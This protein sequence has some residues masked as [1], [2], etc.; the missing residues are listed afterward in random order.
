MHFD[1]VPTVAQLKQRA[2]AEIKTLAPTCDPGDID[3]PTSPSGGLYHALLHS[4]KGLGF[5][6]NT[7]SDSS[8]RP[9]FPCALAKSFTSGQTASN[10]TAS[11]SPAGSSSTTAS[12]SVEYIRPVG[13]RVAA[14]VD[15]AS[16]IVPP[17]ASSPASSAALD[18][19]SFVSPPEKAVVIESPARCV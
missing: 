17:V 13:E 5:S 15:P 2:V 1:G 6:I 12:P 18:P 7:Q 10:P 9:S 19:A 3:D 11:T 16:G 4:F 8:T 14:S